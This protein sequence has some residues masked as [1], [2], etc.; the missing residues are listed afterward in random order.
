MPSIPR[1]PII[2]KTLYFF[3]LLGGEI[4]WTMNQMQ[5]PDRP[6]ESFLGEIDLL[7]HA[8]NLVS[9]DNDVF[10]KIYQASVQ[11]SDI[12][13]WA[14]FFEVYPMFVRSLR[15]EFSDELENPTP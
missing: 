7:F 15:F 2:K 14:D 10:L 11:H 5:D 6:V 4:W 3:T 13:D 9:Y 8:K 12:Q 1:A